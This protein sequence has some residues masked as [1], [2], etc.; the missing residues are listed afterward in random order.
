MSADEGPGAG[1]A[2]LDAVLGTLQVA[3]F[4]ALALGPL[5]AGAV[6]GLGPPTHTATV[7]DVN[8]APTGDGVAYA[9]LSADSRA[10][11]DDLLAADGDRLRVQTAAPPA[12][13]EP[14]AR[15]VAFESYAVRVEVTRS[16]PLRPV[17]LL[18]GL[19]ASTL[20]TLAGAVVVERTPLG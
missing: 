5:V 17:A 10:V 7:V 14:G 19:A 15:T 1:D 2:A 3:V 6:V 12:V 16:T 18:L 11:V 13:L 9:D 4:A 20:T 8:A